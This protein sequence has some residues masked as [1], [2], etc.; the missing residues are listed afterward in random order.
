[1]VAVQTALRLLDGGFR[2]IGL[3]HLVE[4]VDTLLRILLRRLDHVD[5]EALKPVDHRAPPFAVTPMTF[6][7]NR[8]ACTPAP[9][10]QGCRPLLFKA[11]SQVTG[12]SD[13]NRV[14]ARPVL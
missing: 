7:G 10:V 12:A 14:L 8:V 3:R 6:T 2:R 9:L 5:F 13:L 4:V 1:M 11:V